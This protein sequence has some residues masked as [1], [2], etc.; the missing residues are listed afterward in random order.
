[1]PARPFAGIGCPVFR[2]R[3]E[4]RIGPT[5]QLCQN[6]LSSSSAAG[7]AVRSDRIEIARDSIGPAPVL[8][9]RAAIRCRT[10]LSGGRLERLFQLLLLWLPS[11]FWQAL[12]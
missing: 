2:R 6:W 11:S 5:F 9:L 10:S 12:A 3:V 4:S 1:M 7:A 8:S